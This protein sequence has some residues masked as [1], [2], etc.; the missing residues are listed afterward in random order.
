MVKLKFF[1][2][3]FAWK[4]KK[5]ETFSYDTFYRKKNIDEDFSPNL[6]K[7]VNKLTKNVVFFTIAKKGQVAFQRQQNSMSKSSKIFERINAGTKS[8][9]ESCPW[10]V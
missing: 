1:M 3:D 8:L 7:K 9:H 5:N 6:I 4:T 2:N 10:V